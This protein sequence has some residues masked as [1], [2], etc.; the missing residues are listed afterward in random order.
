MATEAELLPAQIDRIAG[1][2]EGMAEKLESFL[3][4]T[5]PEIGRSEVSAAYVAQTLENTYTALE[6]LF[7]RIS[8]HFENALADERRHAD[9]PVMPLVRRDLDRFRGFLQRTLEC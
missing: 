9:L 1:V 3:S 6:T 8:Q 4:A 5:L 2:V 7:L